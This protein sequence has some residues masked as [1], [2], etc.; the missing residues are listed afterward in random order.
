MRYEVK[1]ITKM[2]D[3]V[4]TFFIYNYNSCAKVDLMC[5]ADGYKIAFEFPGL[6]ISDE[7]IARIKKLLKAKRDPSLANYYW[8]LTGEVEDDCE[9]PLVAIM[10]DK[11]DIKKD[12][13]GVQLVIYRKKLE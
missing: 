3:E 7:E 6:Q 4:L 12:E 9:L 10:A 8:Q 1:K 13:T 2:I 11:V 5:Q